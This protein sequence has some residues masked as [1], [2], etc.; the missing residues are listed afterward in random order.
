MS[1][2]CVIACFDFDWA[3]RNVTAS[4]AM[5]CGSCEAYAWC[6]GNCMKNLYLGYVKNDER[7]RANVVEPICAL[8]RFIGREIDRHDPQAWFGRASLAVRREI[9][10]CE[11]YEYVEIMP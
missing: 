8:L 2:S 6:R 3:K 9:T 10:D 11:V 5:P 4:A 1:Q 7:Y